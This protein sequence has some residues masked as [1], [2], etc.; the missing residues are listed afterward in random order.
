MTLLFSVAQKIVTEQVNKGATI[1]DVDTLVVPLDALP[2]KYSVR[3]LNDGLIQLPVSSQAE[4][5]AKAAILERCLQ[6][7]ERLSLE[8]GNSVAPQELI[9]WLMETIR[10]DGACFLD[11]SFDEA[12][13][14]EIEKAREEWKFTSIFALKSIDLLISYGFISEASTMSEVLLSLLAFTQL[15]DTW[16][17]KPAYDISKGALDHQSQEVH[18]GAFIVDYVLKGFIRPLFAKSTPQ[19]IT[20]QGRKAPNENLG[21]RI[22]E[23]PSSPDAIWKPWKCR[24][25]H[26]VTVFKWVVTTADEDLISNN[27]HLFIPPLMTLLD[28][29]TTS[30]RASGLTI[31]SEFLKKTSPRMLVQTGLRDLLEEALMPTLS[32]LPTLTPVA[33]SQL[34]LKKAYSAL[35][36]LGDI[37]YASEDSKPERNR[38][39]DRLMREGVIYGIHHCGDITIILELLLA[40]MSEIINRLHIYSAKHAKDIL[41]LLSAVLVDPFAPSNPALLL[42]GI[43]TVQTTILNCWPI[44]SEEHHRVQIVKALSIC[45]INLTEEIMSSASEDVKHELDQLKQELQI[46]AAL[47]FKSTGGTAGQ[48]TALTDAVNVYPDLSNLFKLE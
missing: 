43:K 29:P 39:Y 5:T 36:E 28:D 6:S 33:E 9:A 4:K 10:P 25:I 32:F 30:V 17:S 22:T 40:E 14:A 8:D 7:R 45:W 37:R 1:D 23:V 20:S 27:W 3:Q 46:S 38:F 35:L 41:P 26:A 31:L 19:T 13:S 48:E 24:D 16:N 18:T 12:N 15:G 21:N 44:L 11:A 2:P 42:R 34:L 47:L